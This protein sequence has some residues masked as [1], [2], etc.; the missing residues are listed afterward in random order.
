MVWP[1]QWP[2]FLHIFT[3]LIILSMKPGVK[4][5]VSEWLNNTKLSCLKA[6]RYSINFR[7]EQSKTHTQ[8]KY[9]MACLI[10]EAFIENYICQATRTETLDVSQRRPSLSMR[11]SFMPLICLLKILNDNSLIVRLF[12]SF[13]LGNSSFIY[14]SLSKILMRFEEFLVYGLIKVNGGADTDLISQFYF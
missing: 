8:Q 7:T 2:C 6:G 12:F 5:S 3:S 13:L 11:Q 10:R 14:S 4:Y 1:I 9:L